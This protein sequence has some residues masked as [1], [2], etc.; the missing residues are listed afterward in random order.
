MSVT[1]KV[2]METESSVLLIAFLQNLYFGEMS[3]MTVGKSYDV[4]NFNAQDPDATVFLSSASESKIGKLL[5]LMSFLP[6]THCLS[7]FLFFCLN[8]FFS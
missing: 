7:C 2:Y 8:E 3:F 6:F 4:V 1:K 5:H